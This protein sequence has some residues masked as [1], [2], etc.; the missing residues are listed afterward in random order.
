VVSQRASGKRRV[1]AL[2]VMIVAWLLAMEAFAVYGVPRLSRTEQRVKDEYHAALALRESTPTVLFVGNSL[3]LANVDLS[4]VG[5]ALQP[6]WQSRRLAVESTSYADW[7]F[8]LRRLFAEGARPDTVVL[9][10]F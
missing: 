10:L 4:V 7:Y 1:V 5:P 9:M 8:G 6:R 3:L 2:L